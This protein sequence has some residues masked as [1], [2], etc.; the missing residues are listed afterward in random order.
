M[1][2]FTNDEGSYLVT[3]L[4]DVHAHFLTDFYVVAAKAAGQEVPDG[5][6]AGRLGASMGTWR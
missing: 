2:G 6:P 3:N 1:D 5:M 4:I